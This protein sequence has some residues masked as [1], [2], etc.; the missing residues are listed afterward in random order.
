MMGNEINEIAF[1]DETQF[2]QAS[3]QQKIQE[4]LKRKQKVPLD[5]L[6]KKKRILKIE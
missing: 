3:D 2:A 4:L 1:D 6:N 5:L